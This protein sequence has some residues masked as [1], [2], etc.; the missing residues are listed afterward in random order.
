MRK[1]IAVCGCPRSGNTAITQMLNLHNKVYLTDESGWM[2][3]FNCER[4]KLEFFFTNK[5]VVGDK[6]P[7]YV[8]ENHFSYIRCHHPEVKFIFTFRRCEDVVSSSLLHGKASKQVWAHDDVNDAIS[9]WN[10]YTESTIRAI[11]SL[12]NKQFCAI[13]F[14]QESDRRIISKIESLID[15][16]LNISDRNN[17]FIRDKYYKYNYHLPLQTLVLNKKIL[18]YI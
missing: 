7:S 3:N 13:N 12:D 9:M 15:M 6:T 14:E 2:S 5:E 1:T 11:N 16:D 18:E 10:E 8:L 4:D 17:L